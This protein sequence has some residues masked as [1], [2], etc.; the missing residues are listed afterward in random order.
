MEGGKNGVVGR[1]EWCHRD[2]KV[3]AALRGKYSIERKNRRF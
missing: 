3:S 1:E 2:P